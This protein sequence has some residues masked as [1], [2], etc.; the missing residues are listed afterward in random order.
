MSGRRPGRIGRA[1][2]LVAAGYLAGVVLL[3]VLAPA[4]APHDPYDQQLADALLPPGTPGQAGLHLLGTDE[5]GRDTFSRLVYGARPILLVAAASVAL[6]ATIGSAVGLI[7]GFARGAVDHLFMRLSD[8]Q[9]SL[10]PLVLAILLAV[11]VSPG[12]GSAVAAISL[13]IWP[14][15]ARVVRAETLRVSTSDY[16]LLA[17]VAGLGRIRTLV[18]HVVPNTLNIVVVLA[19]LNLA[20][21]V[22]FSA[23][24]SV[25]RKSVV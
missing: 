24:L 23:G 1:V 17:R 22:I 7:S 11:A 8:I 2:P 16:V 12:V 13:V 5:L 20:I 4:V 6:A 18:H 10:P 9:L 19:T 21:A 14:Q 15:Y 3:A 25:D